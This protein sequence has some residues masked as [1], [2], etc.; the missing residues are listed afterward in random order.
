MLNFQHNI[1]NDGFPLDRFQYLFSNTLLENKVSIQIG[2]IKEGQWMFKKKSFKVVFINKQGH[3]NSIINGN[4][5]S[6][7]CCSWY[8]ALLI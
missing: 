4:L 3:S 2:K 8:D 6:I 1:C 7:S 5:I